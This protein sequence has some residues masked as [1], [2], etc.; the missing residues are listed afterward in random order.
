[1]DGNRNWVAAS[2]AA[3]AGGVLAGILFAPQ[4][5]REFRRAI[6][7]RALVPAHW[8]EGRFYE[9]E[10]QL[11]ALE[12]EL[13]ATS[14]EFSEKLRDATHRAVAQYVPD[15]PENPEAWDVDGPELTR[16]LPGL[17]R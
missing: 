14:A 8:V 5:G 13:R 1:M 6:A 12:Q 17:P 7:N 9:I 11:E 10:R 15:F 2:I 4:S 16:D 3:F